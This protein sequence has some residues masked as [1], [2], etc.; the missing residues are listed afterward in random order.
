MIEDRDNHLIFLI[1]ANIVDCNYSINLSIQV[2]V[3]GIIREPCISCRS[4]LRRST[5]VLREFEVVSESP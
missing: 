2:I 1:G 4:G 3:S 5:F